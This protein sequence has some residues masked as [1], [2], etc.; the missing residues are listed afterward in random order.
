[1]VIRAKKHF[2]WRRQ[3]AALTTDAVVAIAILGL[4]MLPLSFAFVREMKLCR[5]YYSQAVAMEI[6]DGEMEILAAGE[7][8]SFKPG[9]QTYAVRAEAVKV[10]PPGR[11]ELTVKNERVR[12]E[13]LPDKKDKGGR[14]VREARLK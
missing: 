9:T 6:V 4:T 7:W 1:M 11:F 12:L 13:W 10:L 8:R 5:T 14:V 3:R 2:G